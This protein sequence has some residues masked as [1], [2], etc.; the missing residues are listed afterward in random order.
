[1]IKGFS[2]YITEQ[3]SNPKEDIE[4]KYGNPQL[5]QKESMYNGSD[6]FDVVKDNGLMEKWKGNI[7]P[8]QSS[9]EVK[10][11]IEE[12]IMIGNAQT[13]EDKE[14]VKDSEKDMLEIFVKFLKLNGVDLISVEDLEKIT[15][16][17]DPITFG[18]KYH[19]N[20]PRPYQ[21]AYALQLPL[22]PSQPTNA[23]SPSYPSGHSIDAFVLGGLLSNK[24][25]QLRSGIATI[26]ERLSKSRLQGGIHFPFDSEFGRSIAEDILELEFLSI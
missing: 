7:P 10:K 13:T 9:E 6:L 1:M 3:Y 17:I 22:F 20:Y 24:F 5:W 26:T 4:I 8:L 14:F 2:Q 18:L 23:C 16:K 19:F 11:S 21:L 25:P 12:L 15:D